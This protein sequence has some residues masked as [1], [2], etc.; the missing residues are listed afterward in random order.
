MIAWLIEHWPELLA[1]WLIGT[2]F[3]VWFVWRPLAMANDDRDPDELRVKRLGPGHYAVQ[4][5]P[6]PQKPFGI[7]V[8]V[9]PN[10]PSDQVDVVNGRGELLGRIVNIG[11]DP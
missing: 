6:P 11:K 10:M 2:P 3:V 4:T 7:H 5:D 9:N 8:T 1:T